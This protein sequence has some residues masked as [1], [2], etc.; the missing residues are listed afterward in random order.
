MP[1]VLGL[2]LF[3]AAI[4]IG[5]GASMP[6]M[7]VWFRAEGLS[8]TEIA[9]I[10]SAPQFAR[11]AVGPVIALWADSFRLRR[12]PMIWIGLGACFAYAS[13]AVLHGFWWWLAGWFV[14]TVLLSSLSPLND[15]IT[16]RRAGRDGFAYALPRSIGSLAYICANVGMGLVLLIAPSITVLVWTIVAASLTALAARLCL[17]DEPVRE[18]EGGLDVGALWRGFHGLLNDRIFLLAVLSNS[19]IQAS[20]SFYYSFSALAW[21]R[22]GVPEGWIGALWGFA[23]VAEVLFMWFFEPWRRR[24]GPVGLVAIGGCGAVVRWTAL[25]FSPPLALLFPLQAL[26]ALSFTAAFLGG[27]RLVERL[28]LP[29]S[30]SSA[31]MLNSSLAGGI[32]AGLATMASGPL[33]DALGAHGYLLM[34][35]MALIGLAGAL[36]LGKLSPLARAHG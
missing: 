26:H 20:Q 4:F 18:G 35:L 9:I 16:L 27:L 2:G 13:M 34:T 14:G 15:V 22:Q 19:L 29:D 23:V 36:W 11:I 31:Q 12:T 28:S 32:L 7:P 8:G 10:V 24:V 1:V 17:P 6:F 21:R 5:T 33:F 25:A 30:A 3:Y